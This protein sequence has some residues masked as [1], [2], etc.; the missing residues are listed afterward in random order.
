MAI[1]LRAV[2]ARVKQDTAVSGTSVAVP[3]P[4]GV[5]AGDLLIMFILYDCN[6]NVTPP[7]GWSEPGGRRAAVAGGTYAPP[8][9]DVCTRVAT[10]TEGS[11][12]TIGTPNFP[13]PAG[14][15][16]VLAFTVAYS[17]TEPTSPYEAMA[18][19]A[20]AGNS[21]TAQA[22][23]QI[24][25]INAN[26]WLL[27]LRAR[28]G[29]V[30]TYTDSVGTDV[31]RVQDSFNALSLGF[32]DSN[33]VL[34]AGLQTQRTTTA[35]TAGSSDGDIMFSVALKL[36][37]TAT[38]VNATA[39]TAP[40]AAT[41]YNPTAVAVNGPWDTCGPGGLPQYTWAIDWDL[42][43]NA[44][45]GN[46]VSLNPYIP[47]DLSNWTG[48]NASIARTT[49]LL[50]GRT[51]PTT[52]VTPNGVSASGGVNQSP[53]PAAGTVVPGQQYIADAWVYSPG[54][55]SDLRACI[56]WYDASD[57]FLSSGLGSGSVVAAGTWTHLR[58][59]LTAPASASRP[60]ARVRAGGTPAS[61]NTF[62]VFG[63]MVMDPSVAEA[64][65]TPS[66]LDL[67]GDDMLSDG[68]TW[69][70]GRDQTRQTSPA[71]LGTAA[72]NV[73]N[74]NRT[75]S[76]DWPT[77]PL[78]GNLDAARPMTG[79]VVFNGTVYPLFCGRTDNYGLTADLNNRSVQF[80]FMDLQS[81]IQNNP[82]TT[83]LYNGLRTGA[84][85]DIVLDA[86][87]WTGPRDI[88]LGAT[89]MPWWWLDNTK[90][91]AALDDLVKSEGPPSI[92]Y[93][94]PDGTATFRD[95]THRL[96][97]DA[98]TTVQGHFSA[99]EIDCAAPAVTGLTFTAPFTY[100]NGWRDIINTVNFQVSQREV[101]GTPSVVWSTTNLIPVS[102][103]QTVTLNAVSS[104]PF[105]A[106]QV[107]V[108]GTD[109]TFTGA[110]TPVITL[111][112]TNGLS[113]QIM[114]TALGADV[115]LQGLQ[116][117]ACTVPVVR[118]VSVQMQD[119]VSVS[120]H[121]SQQGSDTSLPWAG[122]ED[123]QAIA[124]IILLRYAQRRP[125][126]QLRVASKDPV[127]YLQVLQ[128]T[129]SDLVQITNGETGTDTTFYVE[130]VAHTAQRMTWTG[131]PPIHSVVLGCEAQG[132]LASGN[133]IVFDQRGSG[134][135]QGQF[136]PF[137]A[138]DP[139]SV[140]IFDDPV[141]GA[142]GVG[143]LGT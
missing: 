82:V 97:R 141:Q 26:G 31:S 46:I 27:T 109:F 101:Q 54:G 86:A 8:T 60:V 44:A 95:R 143:R 6:M 18:I 15:P 104:D 13:W 56:D 68:A 32:F 76:P 136:D 41:A 16:N 73:T 1:A 140:F 57:A 45:A 22:H 42:S 83:G 25:T 92:F 115:L 78:N 64:Q 105:L 49:D 130:H 48:N 96:L 10:G 12:Q 14:N 67:V 118:T 107:P 112:Q 126:V 123:A 135:D 122:V 142:F 24:T 7:A 85:V 28:S 103:G 84:A 137:V 120:Q 61:A 59:T 121:G 66:P 81:V 132:Q 47:Y 114:I 117:Q 127:H 124:E 129:I 3:M 100:Q 80:T 87:G 9:L 50:A 108:A 17:G 53:H 119:P 106:A 43:G 19:G 71:A 74:V 128:R 23:P 11:S 79:Q 33:S 69:A 29:T 4:A 55:W 99:A 51:V 70:Y 72:F 131:R 98:S 40:A 116:L 21:S 110:G 133:P 2:G 58:Q 111:S 93:I 36:S 102:N 37:S 113:A 38:V 77:S 91:G 65:I 52:L 125:I 35:G 88:D 139:T 62:Y 5:V 39:G 138:D 30:A 63:A 90:A 75:Y 94:A 134:F 89:V 34:S 20:V